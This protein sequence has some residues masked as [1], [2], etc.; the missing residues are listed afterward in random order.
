MRHNGF[1]PADLRVLNFENI[2]RGGEF[3]RILLYKTD[4]ACMSSAS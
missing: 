1:G 3:M 4:I 2:L